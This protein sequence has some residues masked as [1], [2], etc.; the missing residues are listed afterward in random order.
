MNALSSVYRRSTVVECPLRSCG[1]RGSA[2]PKR[3]E[4]RE[5]EARTNVCPGEMSE[6]RIR[7]LPAIVIDGRMQ[8]SVR[9]APG[10]RY[11][12]SGA[13]SLRGAD[14][15]PV[16][17]SLVPDGALTN[18]PIEASAH[19]TVIYLPAES[20]PLFIRPEVQRPEE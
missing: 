20:Q 11:T 17:Y 14:W 19:E 13:R 3:E 4:P 15:Q 16:R 8:L 6:Q 10:R 5:S 2:V 9:T 7:Y 1:G 12:F 18:G